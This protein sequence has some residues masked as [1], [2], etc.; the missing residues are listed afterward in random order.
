MKQERYFQWGFKNTNSNYL[1]YETLFFM[2][3]LM[4][5]ANALP[6]IWNS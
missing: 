1:A 5:N 6:S 2:F 4:F 3:A